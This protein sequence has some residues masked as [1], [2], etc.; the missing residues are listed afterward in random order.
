MEAISLKLDETLLKNIDLSLKAHNYSTRTEFIRDAI[1]D[2]LTD[3]NRDELAKMISDKFFG[4]ATV[5]T[6]LKEDRKIREEAGKELMAELDKR[7]K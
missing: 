4:K 5:K 3:L 7:F 2:K 1:R 6:S